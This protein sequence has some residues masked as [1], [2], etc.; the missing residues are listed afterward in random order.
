MEITETYNLKTLDELAGKCWSG[1]V[2]VLKIPRDRYERGEIDF[3][4]ML[5]IS[6]QTFNLIEEMICATFEKVDMTALNDFICFDFLD[7][8]KDV[9][10]KLYQ[11]FTGEKD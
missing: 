7:C 5:E 9:N 11:E 2:R 1:A 8:M 3:V 6:A 4:D 10:P